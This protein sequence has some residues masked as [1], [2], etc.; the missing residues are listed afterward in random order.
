[1]RNSI[2]NTAEYGDYYAGPRVITPETKEAINKSWLTF[3]LVNSLMNSWLIQNGQNSL[4]NI[5]KQLF[6]QSN[7]LVQNFAT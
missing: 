5:V 1:M 3:N 7:Q 2:S 4:K 6:I